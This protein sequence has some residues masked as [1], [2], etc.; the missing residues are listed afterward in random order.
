MARPF[1]LIN[2]GK[3]D[4]W[5]D[6][7]SKETKE[8]RQW[9]IAGKEYLEID[10]C[11]MMTKAML[12]LVLE[13]LSREKSQQGG[14]WKQLFG[15]MSVILFGD[16]HQFPPVGNP[17]AM[18]YNSHTKGEHAEIGRELYQLFTNM[19]IL[20]KQNWV[21]DEGWIALLNHLHVGGCTAD[22]LR[23]LDKL[24]IDK[25]EGLDFTA[26]PWKDTIFVMSWH[27]PKDRWNDEALCQ[28]CYLS[29]Q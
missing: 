11:S 21:Q 22:D 15:G 26:T 10:E 24:V 17:S 5:Y 13:V 2:P 25:T 27:G 1:I 18:L 14:H 29:G 3:K 28:H 23:E 6:K 16:F 9:N 12:A 19:V 7:G 8:K 4:D 20:M